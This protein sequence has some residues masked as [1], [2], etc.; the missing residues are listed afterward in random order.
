[1]SIVHFF[2][3]VIVF[4]LALAIVAGYVAT[5]IICGATARRLYTTKP[6]EAAIRFDA[7]SYVAWLASQPFLV[8][9]VC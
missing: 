4:L 7:S 5:K 8:R 9:W 1:M 3:G 6:V 2:G